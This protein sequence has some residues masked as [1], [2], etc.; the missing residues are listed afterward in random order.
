MKG[1]KVAAMKAKDKIGH[2]RVDKTGAV[3][4]KKVKM[5]GRTQGAW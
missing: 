4:Y 2:R 5:A 1:D 3:T